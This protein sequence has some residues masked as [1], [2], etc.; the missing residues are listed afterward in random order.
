MTEER[1]AGKIVE[2][3][4]IGSYNEFIGA[5][6]R[7]PKKLTGI[8]KIPMRVDRA[9]RLRSCTRRHGANSLNMRFP[10]ALANKTPPASGVFHFQVSV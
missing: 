2:T 4:K 7:I 1:L 9:W 6:I 5:S 8:R 10:S 3:G